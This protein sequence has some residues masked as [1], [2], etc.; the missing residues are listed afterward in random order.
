MQSVQ[1]VLLP[2]LLQQ[3]PPVH[4]FDEQWES[5]EQELPSDFVTMH[6]SPLT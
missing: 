3:L 4:E 6:S 1:P 2:L 5:D